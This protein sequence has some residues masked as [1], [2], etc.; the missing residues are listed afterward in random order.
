MVEE[1][2]MRKGGGLSFQRARNIIPRDTQRQ[3]SEKKVKSGCVGAWPLWRLSYALEH[4]AFATISPTGP[5]LDLPDR[6]STTFNACPIAS[7]LLSARYKVSLSIPSC[8]SQISRLDN[9]TQRK[10]NT[11]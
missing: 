3:Q 1:R 4:V 9:A 5:I 2:Q 11:R 6:Y 10:A 7:E 8:L